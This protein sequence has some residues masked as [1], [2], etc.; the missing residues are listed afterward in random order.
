MKEIFEKEDDPFKDILGQEKAKR[1]IMSA[2][3]MNRN[4]AIFGPPG[5]GKTTIAK[6]IASQGTDDFYFRRGEV[7]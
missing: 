3:L 1:Q 6:I 4:I 2:L 7:R 5:I